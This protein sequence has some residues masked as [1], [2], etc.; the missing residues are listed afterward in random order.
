MLPKPENVLITKEARPGFSP[1]EAENI[2][3]TS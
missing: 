3:K 2:L 1:S